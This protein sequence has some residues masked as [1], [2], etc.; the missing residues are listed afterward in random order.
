MRFVVFG[1]GAIGGVVGARLHQAG[2]DVTLIA[3]GAHHDAIASRGLLLETPLERV[4]LRIPVVSAPSQIDFSPD[5]VI[6]LATKTQDSEGALNALRAATEVPVAVVCLQNGVENERIA[7]RRFAAV[8]AAVVM[9][10]SAHLEPGVVQA[11]ATNTT[12]MI[13]IGRYPSGVDDRCVA[14]ASALGN[15]RIDS[16]PTPEVMRE[17]YAK[18]LANLGNAV[19]AL[20][21]DSDAARELATLAEDEGRAVLGSG[22]IPFDAP[23]VADV[24]GRWVR[25]G[26]GRIDGRPRAG[27]STWQSVRRGLPVET[28]FLNG[29]IILLGRLSGIPTP[30]NERIVALMYQTVRER[31]EPGS[32]N[33]RQ[34]LDSLRR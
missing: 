19:E 18:L 15:A 24:A 28:A 13:N 5:D 26:V 12:G 10:P 16:A 9:M 7:L 14:I 31:R 21:G 8:Y 22:G 34:V 32:L 27:G 20:C 6:L 29:E 11:Y 17:K 4:L 1:A 23:D 25:W 2:E 30:V 3:R 33:A